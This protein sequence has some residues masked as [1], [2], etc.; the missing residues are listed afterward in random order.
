[1][2]KRRADWFAS[3]GPCSCGS[4]DR[5]ELHHKDPRKKVSHNVWSWADTSRNAELAKCEPKCYQCHKAIT[6]EQILSKRPA[7]GVV[8]QYRLGCKCDLCRAANTSYERS[9]RIKRWGTTSSK[10]PRGWKEVSV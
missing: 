10:P 8:A 5:L 1:M 4:W 3:N 9:R 2:K 7:H 6:R